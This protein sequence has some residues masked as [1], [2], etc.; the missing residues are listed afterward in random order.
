MGP[1]RGSKT[2][3]IA[4]KD[5]SKRQD[6]FSAEDENDSSELQNSKRQLDDDAVDQTILATSRANSTLTTPINN[7]SNSALSTPNNKLSTSSSEC[8]STSL[9]SLTSISSSTASGAALL[10]LSKKARVSST[11]ATYRKSHIYFSGK[12]H[13]FLQDSMDPIEEAALE[14]NEEKVFHIQKL[15]LLL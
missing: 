3:A 6:L 12:K 13:L 9:S 5:A 10:P 14:L 8:N 4:N 11:G 2:K 15:F 1:K 7:V